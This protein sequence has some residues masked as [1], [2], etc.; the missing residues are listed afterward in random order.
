MF[1]SRQLAVYTRKNFRLLLNMRGIANLAGAI[2]I[3]FVI[4]FVFKQDE[5]FIHY[6]PTKIA[7]FAFTCGAIWI[8]LFNSVTSICS[9]RKIV[10]FEYQMKNLDLTAYIMSRIRT[11]AALCGIEAVLM[12]IVLLVSYIEN[13]QDVMVQVPLLWVTIFL[14]M[15]SSD[16]L[17]VLISSI[18][19]KSSVAMTVMPF[20]L[21]VQLIFSNFIRRLSEIG[22]L[23]EKISYLTI[24]R[25]GGT[26][27]FSIANRGSLISEKG[28]SDWTV[29]QADG[30]LYTFSVLKIVRCWGVLICFS[31]IFIFVATQVLKMVK[32]DQR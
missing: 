14:I 24:A 31:F 30:S 17:A 29:L 8:G 20:V 16:A 21:I 2:I 13:I 9:E 7:S 10:K 23:A 4:T 32:N 27:F 25:W 3:P 18:V 1:N 11:E 28:T 6:Q 22:G 15:F 19:K 12:T 5:M 26:A